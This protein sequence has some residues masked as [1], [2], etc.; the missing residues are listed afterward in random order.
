[1][2]FPTPHGAPSAS[3]A[4]TY[5]R[6]L[7]PRPGTPLAA[8][9]SANP[10][11]AQANRY[12]DAELDSA[13]PMQLVVMLYDKMLV[14]LRRARAGTVAGDIEERTEQTL[15]VVDMITELKLSL[16][17]EAGGDI[18][19]QLDALYAFMLRELVASTRG[20]DVQKLDVVL[21]IAGEL[22][23]AFAGAHAQLAAPQGAAPRA[24][25]SA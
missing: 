3:S 2:A 18:S 17:H 1:M 19:R 4:P 8:R 13:S 12:R 14:T 22:R 15:K 24:V 7:A 21:R 25:R 11:T 6:P 23:E 9:P 5:A 16:D 20:G 10:Y